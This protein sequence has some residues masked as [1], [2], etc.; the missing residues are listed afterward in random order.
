VEGRGD[1]FPV[2]V[3]EGEGI[4]PE[5]VAAALDVLDAVSAAS[6]LRFTI[7]RGPRWQ[8]IDRAAP[9]ALQAEV[10]EYCQA[11]FAAD[12]ALLCGP[13]GGRFVYDLRRRFDLFCKLSPVRWQPALRDVVRLRPEF[14]EGVDILVVRD[15]AA[16]IYQG[17]WHCSDAPGRGRTAHHQFQYSERDV[18]RLIQIALELA[19]SRRGALAVILKDGGIPSISELWR[20]VAVSLTASDPV[21]L[22]LINI[23]YAAYRLI[24]DPRSFDV[25][26]TPNMFGD[27]LIDLTGVL[28]GSRGMTFSGNFS[29]EG[30]AVYQTNH[31]AA[32]ALAGSNRAN[33]LGQIA[34][35]A[36]M[37]RQS[38]GLHTAADVIESAV[39][40][41]LATRWRTEEIATH[42]CRVVGTRELGA[43]VARTVAECW[44][45]DPAS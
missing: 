3:L 10:A 28:I 5:V 8:P 37:L 45:A 18:E 4:G 21:R 29:A 40:R 27:L 38:F 23:D 43:L 6:G 35:L 17:S 13:G 19:K 20:E 11:L 25:I 24:H 22:E 1:T 30:A 44:P 33:P 26:V 41:T 15:N 7:Q 16:G 9:M 32:H 36:M 42:G 12:G 34:A 14:L 31:G 2:G 39:A